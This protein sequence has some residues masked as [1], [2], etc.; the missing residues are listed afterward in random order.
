[1]RSFNMYF[2][3][4]VNFFCDDLFKSVN[5]E[6]GRGGLTECEKTN[7]GSRS[8]QT[9]I[10]PVFRFLLL[11]LSVCKKGKKMYLWEMVKLI[12]KKQK[13]SLFLKKK[14]LVRLTPGF[15][16]KETS[17]IPE[18]LSTESTSPG[19]SVVFAFAPRI[20]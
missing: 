9:L 13:N 10:F 1:M 19:W 5:N 16:F 12:S 8:Y 15:G 3:N 7:F 18:W 4:L 2:D 17:L 20:F 6:T 11:C 14:S